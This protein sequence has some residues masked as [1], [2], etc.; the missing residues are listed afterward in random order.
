M[1]GMRLLAVVAVAILVCHSTAEEVAEEKGYSASAHKAEVQK[2]GEEEAK[3]QIAEA[4]KIIDNARSK[5]KE[6][7]AAAKANARAIGSQASGAAKAATAKAVEKVNEEA[8]A[9]LSKAKGIER[10]AEANGEKART[11]ALTA[12][13]AK[14]D[15]KDRATAAKSQLNKAKI[16][17]TFARAK[18]AE[19]A[20]ARQKKEIT[21]ATNAAKAKQALADAKE[22]KAALRME[23]SKERQLARNDKIMANKLK[24]REREAAQDRKRARK[25]VRQAEKAQTEIQIAAKKA[26]RKAVKNAAILAAVEKKKAQTAQSRERTGKDLGS[27]NVLAAQAQTSAE[28][29]MAK[30]D[31]AKA[32]AIM[33]KVKKSKQAALSE[34]KTAAAAQ[35]RKEAGIRNKAKAEKKL[36]AKDSAALQAAH[37]QIKKLKQELGEAQSNS[38][39]ETLLAGLYQAVPYEVA[40]G[41]L[42][43]DPAK[44]AVVDAANR[45][46]C[47]AKCAG[48]LACKSFQFTHKNCLLSKKQILKPSK[49]GQLMACATKN[50]LIKPNMRSKGSVFQKRSE[51]DKD[52]LEVEA[53]IQEEEGKSSSK[54]ERDARRDHKA[55]EQTLVAKV[56][57]RKVEGLAA[58]NIS[59]KHWAKKLNAVQKELAQCNAEA[60]RGG[61]SRELRKAKKAAEKALREKEKADIKAAVAKTHAKDVK[62]KVLAL[63]RAT[64]KAQEAAKTK[65]NKKVA[66][67]LKGAADAAEAKLAKG[68]KDEAIAKEA[69]KK[70]LSI[71]DAEKKEIAENKKLAAKVGAEKTDMLLQKK[72]KEAY[73]GELKEAEAHNKKKLDAQKA[74][75]RQLESSEIKDAA[76]KAEAQQKEADEKELRKKL[77][78][79]AKEMA[80]GMR[81]KEKEIDELDKQIKKHNDKHAANAKHISK[82][83]RKLKKADIKFRSTQKKWG[84]KMREARRKYQESV[85]KLKTI[86]NNH[87]TQA[88]LAKRALQLCEMKERGATG[89]AAARVARRENRAVK[90]A[91]RVMHEKEAAS[92]MKKSMKAKLTADIASKM[93]KEEASKVAKEVKKLTGKK[94]SPKCAACTKLD[95]AERKMLNAD[96]KACQ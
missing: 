70:A 25:M 89:R 32:K 36:V 40:C 82:L 65:A 74:K 34:V 1:R 67:E 16:I 47:A 44:L 29:R 5:A 50:V 92:N 38:A 11:A 80:I 46:S 72:E 41:N 75:V 30:T 78:N 53:L 7:I 37:N 84:K 52:E 23:V 27:A 91:K 90:R 21:V 69:L 51:E 59:A 64:T 85:D 3:L 95:E 48:N 19:A 62:D 6:I 2:A 15:S 8:H 20:E 24:E 56:A 60:R 88:E 83:S 45:G 63:A 22:T 33:A 68:K 55:Y 77:V 66:G 9:L 58:E 81:L 61:A 43:N 79:A 94:L 18:A 31:I 39:G 71:S 49:Y 35:A 42:A 57:Q 73:Q 10:E 17:K 54:I 93:Q 96:C 87:L 28:E 4:K 14:A 76:K 13:R 26:I 86:S 12:E